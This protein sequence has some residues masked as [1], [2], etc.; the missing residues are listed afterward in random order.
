MA[1]ILGAFVLKIYVNYCWW[2]AFQSY[3]CSECCKY[4]CAIGG[5][6]QLLY[7]PVVETCVDAVLTSNRTP[8]KM[9]FVLLR[10]CKCSWRLKIEMLEIDARISS[11]M[12]SRLML[13]LRDPSVAMTKSM[14]FPPLS[15]ASMFVT[16]ACGQASTSMVM[17]WALSVLNL[18]SITGKYNYNKLLVM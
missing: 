9:S 17:P 13:N 14:S 18:L 12:I 4:Y 16:P 3:V 11:I 7:C 6:R 1:C 2:N 8:L 10:M 5:N 15:H